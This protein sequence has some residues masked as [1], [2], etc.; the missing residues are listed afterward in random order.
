MTLSMHDEA[1]L[2][3]EEREACE[4]GEKIKRTLENTSNHSNIKSCKE[5]RNY[6]TKPKEK[7]PKTV[8]SCI[9]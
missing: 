7:I 5:S 6:A 1:L 3:D 2:K 9:L 4:S 8:S